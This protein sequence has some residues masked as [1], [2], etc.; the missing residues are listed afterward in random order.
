MTTK[1]AIELAITM[2]TSI[3][4]RQW[5]VWRIWR[6]FTPDFR[7]LGI[8][9]CL[10]IPAGLLMVWTPDLHPLFSLSL[11]SAGMTLWAAGAAHGLNL[12]PEATAFLLKSLGKSEEDH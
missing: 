4:F 5:V 7:S 2:G 9:L 12:A 10:T 8:I 11:K 1:Q 3:T 6:R